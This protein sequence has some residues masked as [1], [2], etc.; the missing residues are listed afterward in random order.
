ME[1]I[2]SQTLMLPLGVVSVVDVGR[3][4]R[5]IDALNTFMRSAEVRQPG[6]SLKLPKTSKLLDEFL[7]INK[8]S[9]LKNDD[10]EEVALYLQ[11]LRKNAPTIHMSFS[12][13]PSPLFTQR[14]ISWLRQ[15][16]HQSIL[17]QVGLQPTIGAGAVVR[18]TN[19]YFDLSLREFFN[20]KKAVLLAKMRSNDTESDQTE[21]H[22][23]VVGNG[24]GLQN[25]AT[26]PQETLVANQ[27][28]PSPSE[29]PVSEVATP[30]IQEKPST[31][32]MQTTEG[33]A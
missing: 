22:S 29:T 14:L 21:A 28:N 12:A 27:N 30:A 7:E 11:E 13:D 6:T 8:K 15:N 19:K 1:G 4:Q 24:S 25:T 5:E 32:V 18:T 31:E 3:L 23:D 10:R 2:N 20:Q 17:L 9:A 26:N 16:I 33:E